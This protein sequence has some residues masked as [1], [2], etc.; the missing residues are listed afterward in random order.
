[1]VPRL[2]SS[3]SFR[4]GMPIV[5]TPDAVKPASMIVEGMLL[6]AVED[7][8][9]DLHKHSL[10]SEKHNTKSQHHQ[11]S[12]HDHEGNYLHCFFFHFC[13]SSC[14]KWRFSWVMG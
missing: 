11:L 9:H 7:T 14:Q 10:Y 8:R 13:Y 4:Q 2:S 3:T 12:Q 6:S 1:M 5:V